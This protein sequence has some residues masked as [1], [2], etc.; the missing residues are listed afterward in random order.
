M[1]T[2]PEKGFTYTDPRV[3][4]RPVR[5]ISFFS[6]IDIAMGEINKMIRITL[7]RIIPTTMDIILMILG[8]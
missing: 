3:M 7:I 5:F 4:C 6:M 1:W 8:L 2:Y